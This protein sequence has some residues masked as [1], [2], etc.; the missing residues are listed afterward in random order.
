MRY[1]IIESLD[2]QTGER[3]NGPRHTKASLYIHV[4]MNPV[5]G[6]A[7]YFEKERQHSNVENEKGE[8]GSREEDEKEN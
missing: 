7:S 6:T 1:G 5:Y 3:E 8:E 2:V 4:A